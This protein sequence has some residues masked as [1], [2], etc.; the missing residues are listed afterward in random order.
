MLDC[1]KCPAIATRSFLQKFNVR[2]RKHNKRLFSGFDLLASSFAAME[3][4]NQ[5][6]QVFR[7][8]DANG[9]G[10]ISPF[11]LSEVLL[12]LGQEKST[13]V[14]EAIVMVREVDCN[15]DGFIDLDEFMGVMNPPHSTVGS[16]GGSTGD[17][18]DGMMDAFLIFDSDKDGLISAKEL[19]RVLISLG[20]V[21]CSLHDCKRMINGVDK[22]GDGFVDFD[23]FRSM[24]A[25]TTTAGSSTVAT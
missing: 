7:L 20:C 17:D 21:K 15:G 6:K 14:E 1:F 13:A 22:N 8:L 2:R 10:K 18:D 11:E 23:E 25:G 19:Q 4:P 5:L 9:D 24:M 16:A 12:W 3:V